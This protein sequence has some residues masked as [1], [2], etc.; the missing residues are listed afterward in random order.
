MKLAI[1]FDA[2]IVVQEGRRY[3]D[4]VSPLQFMAGARDALY[5]LR[6]AGHLLLL[7]SARASRA[8][9]EDPMLDPFVRA[10]EV[11]ANLSAWRESRFIHRARYDQML[12]FVRDKLPGCFHAID[13]GSAGKP[14]VDLFIDDR[15]L[16]FGLGENAVG[17]QDIA[18]AYGLALPERGVPR[19]KGKK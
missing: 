11:D 19:A 17:W 13:D 7:W 6:R 4:V 2:T 12:R 8:L 3:E 14:S 18:R 9:L 10:G 16:R 1:D 15:A 5:S